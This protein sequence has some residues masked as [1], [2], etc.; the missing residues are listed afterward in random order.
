V[1]FIGWS[2]GMNSKWTPLYLG[3]TLSLLTACMEDKP[4]PKPAPKAAPVQEEPE[5]ISLEDALNEEVAKSSPAAETNSGTVKRESETVHSLTD[6]DFIP[7]IKSEGDYVLQVSTSTYQ[8]DADA[9][10]RKIK[11]LGYDAY[12][13]DVD[14]PAD[15]QGSY[16]RVRLGYFSNV[17]DARSFGHNVL[18]PAGISFWIDNAGNDELMGTSQ[19]DVYEEPSQQEAVMED[20]WGSP[21]EATPAEQTAPA[22]EVV[23]EPSIQKSTPVEP[24]VQEGAP[25]AAEPAPATDDWG[26]PEAKA[27][28]KVVSEIKED[29]PA[30]VEAVEKKAEEVKQEVVNDSWETKPAAAATE[31]KEKAKA[32]TEDDGWE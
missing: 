1:Y 31:T 24:P 4:E 30:A 18:K 8:R 22:P 2:S 16:I 10:I 11:N 9:M 15:L 19:S 27:E 26:T 21:A 5:L 32:W 12:T 20:E 25:A 13:V 28:P 3:I 14:N 7:Q 29:A 17:P 6:S 23:E